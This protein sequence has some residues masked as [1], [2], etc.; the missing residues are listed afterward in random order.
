M[1]E[2]F[3]DE[4]EE[5]ASSDE[6]GVFDGPSPGY[7][8]E[9]ITDKKEEHGVIF[10]FVRWERPYTDHGW[11][12]LTNLGDCGDKIHEYEEQQEGLH[13]QNK[14]KADL[15]RELR[16]QENRER[17]ADMTPCSGCQKVFK[18]RGLARHMQ[19]C[20]ELNGN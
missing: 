19:F 1:P 6:E 16:E 13:H 17:E 3:E 10:Y 20:K 2:T 7:Y 9:S 12:P 5:S 8:V 15:A 11:Q 4:L 14:V 18:K